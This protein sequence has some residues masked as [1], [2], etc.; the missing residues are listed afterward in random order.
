MIGGVRIVGRLIPNVGSRGRGVT[1]GA[2]AGGGRGAVG[3]KEGN[4]GREVTGG[5]A[6][7][8]WTPGVGSC[9]EGVLTGGAKAE[10]GRGAVG[11]RERNCGR[12][13]TGGP[14]TDGRTPGVWFRN[15][16]TGVTGGPT[17][18]GERN[19]EGGGEVWF[20]QLHG[21]LV[22]GITEKG[23]PGNLGRCVVGEI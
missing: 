15:C 16:G 21:L 20:R 19:T 6:T 3:I 1:G 9:G 4:C 11:M 10:G 17:G 5:P 2:K 14:A 8:G 18:T 23:N 22:V 12:E 13:V 7:D